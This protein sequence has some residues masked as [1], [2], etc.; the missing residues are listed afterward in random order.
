MTRPCGAGHDLH[1]IRQ[2]QRAKDAT[3]PTCNGSSGVRPRWRPS[4]R[5]THPLA[6]QGSSLMQSVRA[7]ANGGRARHR[8]GLTIFSRKRSD[9]ENKEGAKARPPSMI[10]TRAPVQLRGQ[11][12][13]TGPPCLPCLSIH[14]NNVYSVRLTS[15]IFPARIASAK[16]PAMTFTNAF[17]NDPIMA[18]GSK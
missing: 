11:A 15:W 17:E 6:L 18:C 8:G 13:P 7:C 12:D 9:Y 10:S 3:G 14:D 1:G 16:R 4:A 2:A 5:N